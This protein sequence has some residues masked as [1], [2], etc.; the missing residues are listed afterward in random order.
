MINDI[1]ELEELCVVSTIRTGYSILLTESYRPG[2]SGTSNR[3][4]ELEAK[5]PHS[6]P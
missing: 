4:S 3:A 6:S 5:R 2:S 1:R